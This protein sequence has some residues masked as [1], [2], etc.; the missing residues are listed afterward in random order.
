MWVDRYDSKMCIN[1]AI[2]TDDQA[3]YPLGISVPQNGEY[4]IFLD[5][6]P[7][8][9]STL[10]LTYDGEVI[11]NLSYGF[12]VAHLEKGT[13]THYGL[14]IVKTPKVATGIDNAETSGKDINVYKIIVDDK[15]FIIRGNQVYGIDGRLAK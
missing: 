5:D 14:R 15:V 8:S 4:D 3:Y 7:D 2:P 10:Y 12:Y 9:E 1:T 13:N 11:W 6:E